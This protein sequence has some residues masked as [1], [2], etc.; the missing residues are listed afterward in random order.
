MQ[1]HPAPQDHNSQSTLVILSTITIILVIILVTHIQLQK[2]MKGPTDKEEPRPAL[3]NPPPAPV[4]PTPAPAQRPALVTPAPVVPTPAPAQRPALVTPAPVVSA[5]APAQ[6]PAPTVTA[7]KVLQRQQTKQS[8]LTSRFHV[9]KPA[10]NQHSA[11]KPSKPFTRNYQQPGPVASQTGLQAG[12]Q[13]PVFRDRD[14]YDFRPRAASTKIAR[15]GYD[16]EM[17]TSDDGEV[18]SDKDDR[19][20]T[21]SES[22]EDSE[23]YKNWK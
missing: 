19:E 2:R 7:G 13:W 10:V 22:S 3:T 21:F 1:E 5:P 6:R 4:V 17:T 14:G 18:A 8:A 9:V 12:Q 11:T 16:E 15:D 20:Y 23:E